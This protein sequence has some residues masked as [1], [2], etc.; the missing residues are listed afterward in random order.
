MERTAFRKRMKQQEA[1]FIFPVTAIIVL[2]F[3]GLMLNVLVTLQSDIAFTQKRWQAFEV[4]RV[5][6]MAT[7]DIISLIQS[8]E[9]AP[10]DIEGKTSYRMGDVTYTCQRKSDDVYNIYLKLH[11]GQGRHHLKVIYDK[12][13]NA[14]IRWEEQ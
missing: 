12:T 9:Q 7:H 11:V 5:K 2:L 14:I 4:T 10:N 6:Q 8:K 3:I 13:D 1:G